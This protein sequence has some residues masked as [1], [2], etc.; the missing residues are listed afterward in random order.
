MYFGKL[1]QTFRDI[2]NCCCM[3]IFS[4]FGGLSQLS[5]VIE[6]VGFKF[7]KKIICALLN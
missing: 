2:I 4:L 3:M 6:Y 1:F 5:F 7:N